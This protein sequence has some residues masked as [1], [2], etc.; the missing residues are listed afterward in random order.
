MEFIQRRILREN[1]ISRTNDVTY[2]EVTASTITIKV[3]LYQ[4]MDDMGMTTDMVYFPKQDNPSNAVDYSILIDK[5]NLSGFTF[6]FMTGATITTTP[7]GF[8]QTLR[9]DDA[10]AS[11]WFMIAGRI[12]GYTDS[13]KTIVKGYNKNNPYIIG[14]DADAEIYQNYNNV[15][16]DGRT[17]L[18]STGVTFTGY[19]VDAN[20]DANIGTPNQ[21]SGI[22]YTD[23]DEDRDV[24]T[25]L[26][27]LGVRV[28]T[29]G[30]QVTTFNYIGEGF[31]ET[32]SQL[33]AI[34]R[35]E[36]LLGITTPPEV[37]SDLFID[38]GATTV[39][40][41]HLRLSEIEGLDHMTKYGNGFY[42][43]IKQ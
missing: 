23:Y 41:L 10:D 39:F 32:N 30:I 31:N 42:N 28:D 18:T 24:V 12:T 9:L 25:D 22:L 35:E 33:S 19:T 4:T 29:E 21:T 5:L 8:T 27:G 15:T 34:T 26:E 38:R 2:G 6:P 40:D 14:F 36:Y 13:K 3:P 43:L 16:I 1:L 37:Q 7:T 11:D 20:L 17:R